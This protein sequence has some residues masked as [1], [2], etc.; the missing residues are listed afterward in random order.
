MKK[1]MA[2]LA[3]VLL[4]VLAC[5]GIAGAEAA[6]GQVLR[7]QMIVSPTS[8][9]K[10][11][12]VRAAVSLTN[13]S[14]KDF[15][16]AMTLSDPNDRQITGFGEPV[17]KD[18]ESA[19]WIGE[20]TVT[21]KDL[22]E[23]K[24]VFTVRYVVE[25]EN[26]ETKKKMTRL[27]YKITA[28][29]DEPEPTP[30]PT[31]EPRPEDFP[32]VV[33]YG[34][35]RPNP[36]TGW[37]AVGCVDRA[38]D[39][40][41]AGRADVKWPC[42]DE[43]I[44]EMLRTRRGMQK[45]ENLIGSEADGTRMNDAWF[46]TDVPAMVEA[47]PMPETEP[48][49]TGYDVG[50]EAVYGLRKNAAGE[51]ESVLL[52]M[53]GS[54]LYENPSPDAQRLYLFMWRLMT[55]DEIFNAHGIGF[56]TEGT[57]PQ[58]FRG[59]SVREF[60]G[61]SDGDLSQAAVSAV[62]LDAEG[63]PLEAKLSPE[64]T[65]ALRTLAERGMVIRK[66]NRWIMPEDTLTCIFTDGQGRELGRIRLFSYTEGMDEDGENIVLTLAA[67]DDGMYQT[68]LMPQP[69]DSLT[70]EELRMMT[71]RIEGVDYT[72]GKSTPRDLI[73]SGWTCFPE[74]AGVFTYQDPEMNDTI[75]VS[76][77]GY[78][79]DEPILHISCQFAYEIDISYCGYDGIPDPDDPDDPD[80]GYFKDDGEET[81]NGDEGIA[82]P[83][84]DDWQK[85]WGAL[86]GWID[87]VIGAGQDTS[88]P[89]VPVCYPLSDGRYLYLYSAVSPISIT[90][91]EHGPDEDI[92]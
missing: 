30:E 29:P 10:G 3:A 19:S 63:G 36:S 87:D 24:L 79:L 72:V 53:A 86:T 6:K 60:Y 88:E 68:A 15:P 80:W 34:V 69:V 73:R 56:A 82:G 25:D 27:G 77:A 2:V 51:E 35:Y 31:P 14:G 70:E 71:V 38:G 1:R 7:V 81:K 22:E 91:S 33:L 11:D 23:G 17:L 90:L 57:S 84:E 78:S 64:E 55:L 42:R 83:E 16:G 65:D 76:T 8:L 62:W 50:Q 59:I 20:W 47:V 92:W 39:V 48:R 44:R 4:A 45:Y 52:G 41:L 26:G 61:F 13:V 28:A 12:T 5:L 89:G 75:E 21:E 18:G 58:G 49:K 37:V 66:E 67:A 46:F 54:Y 85:Q 40:W 43:A 74:Q 9:K 32:D